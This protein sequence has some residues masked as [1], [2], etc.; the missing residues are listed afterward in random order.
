MFFAFFGNLWGKVR[1][2]QLF[3]KVEIFNA[4]NLLNML[5]KV[6]SQFF[7]PTKQRKTNKLLQVV[8]K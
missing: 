4:Q 6:Y 1:E 2:N 8:T 7:K 5:G 3:L